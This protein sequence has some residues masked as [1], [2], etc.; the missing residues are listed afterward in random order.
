VGYRSP[1]LFGVRGRVK[2]ILHSRGA[3]GA[4]QETWMVISKKTVRGTYWGGRN[5]TTGDTQ[6]T[7]ARR[8]GGGKRQIGIVG[9]RGGSG[10]CD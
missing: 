4:T 6:E 10:G 8:T 1:V 3:L 9:E 2:K 5:R 7:G